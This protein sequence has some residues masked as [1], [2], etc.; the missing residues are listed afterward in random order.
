MSQLAAVRG[1]I[2]S[3]AHLSDHLQGKDD[4]VS[5]LDHSYTNLV[6]N[7]S[8]LGGYQVCSTCV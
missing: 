1:W 6:Y 8:N 7:Q 5:L 2:V 4:S 3:F